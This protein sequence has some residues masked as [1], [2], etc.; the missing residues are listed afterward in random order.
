MS[1]FALDIVDLGFREVGVANRLSLVV[2]LFHLLR[3]VEDRMGL[4]LLFY[5]F[6][7]FFQGV[8]SY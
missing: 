6:P 1:D 7:A 3:F 5:H 2:H 4:A 8:W